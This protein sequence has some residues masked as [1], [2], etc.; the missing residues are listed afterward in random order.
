MKTPNRIP[1][2]ITVAAAFFTCTLCSMAQPPRGGPGGPGHPGGPGGPNGQGQPPP[3]PVGDMNV[4]G[5]MADKFQAYQRAQ[6]HGETFYTKE[7]TELQ[8]QHAATYHKI[9]EY[10]ISDKITET[11]G[12]DFVTRLITIGTQHRTLIA[13]GGAPTTKASLGELADAVSTAARQQIKEEELTPDINRLQLQMNELVRFVGN[14]V[15]IS[16]K[17]SSLKRH[18]D[19]LIDK[20][21]RAKEDREVSDRERE[22]LTKEAAETWMEFVKII[23]R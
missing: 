4:F 14:D 20:E 2:N 17:T 12:N 15:K 7:E 6:H 10:L 23:R 19:S 22:K 13:D 9:A 16:S 21:S 11:E 3:P 18:L 5:P 1:Y 8:Q